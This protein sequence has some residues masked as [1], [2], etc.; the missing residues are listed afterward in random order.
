MQQSKFWDLP[1]CFPKGSAKCPDCGLSLACRFEWAFYTCSLAICQNSLCHSECPEGISHEVKGDVSEALRCPWPIWVDLHMR[2]LR[3]SLVGLSVE[4]LLG[5]SFFDAFQTLAAVHL[6]A[7]CP[8][9][10]SS[11]KPRTP[12][13]VREKLISLVV[14][15]TTG[16][17]MHS[18][19]HSHFSLQEKSWFSKDYLDIEHW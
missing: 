18:V 10:L 15:W 1:F 2:S 19:T 13:G 3:G 4:S 8:V 6:A 7:H 16:E 12:H 11:S 9:E 5:F 14:S 17:V